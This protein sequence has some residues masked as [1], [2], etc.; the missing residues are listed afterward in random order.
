MALVTNA[1]MDRQVIASLSKMWGC[2][3]IRCVLGGH[4][5]RQPE[6]ES[7]PEGEI[8]T[9]GQRE[10]YQNLTAPPRDVIDIDGV[11][12]HWGDLPHDPSLYKHYTVDE[13]LWMDGAP[14]SASR[15]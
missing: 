12:Y 14:S 7:E 3:C 5:C 8:S 1:G 4:A 15:R 9:S 11:F 6:P 2:F 13:D 10:C